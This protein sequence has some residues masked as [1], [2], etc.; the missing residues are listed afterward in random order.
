MVVYEKPQQLLL[1]KTLMNKY[2]GF[3]IDSKKTPAYIMQEEKETDTQSLTDIGWD[4]YQ[5]GRLGQCPIPEPST[6]GFLGFGALGLLVL[7]NKRRIGGAT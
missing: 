2:I 7:R 3:D 1:Q 4:L 5:F 6:I